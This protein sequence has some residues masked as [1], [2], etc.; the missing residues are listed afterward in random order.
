MRLIDTAP[1]APCPTTERPWSLFDNDM[2]R[3]YHRARPRTVPVRRE[4]EELSASAP[5]LQGRTH[6]LER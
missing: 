5:G 4:R 2:A 3:K 1:L 6:Y